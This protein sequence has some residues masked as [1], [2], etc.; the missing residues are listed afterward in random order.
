MMTTQQACGVLREAL[1]GRYDEREITAMTR[2]IFDEVLHYSPVDM[3]LREQEAL[4]SFFE[5]RLSAIVA[6]LRAGEPL[7]YVLGVARFHGHSFAVNRDV[8]IPRPETEQL[9]DMIVDREHGADL[10]VVDLCTGSGCIAISLALA[11]RF[12]QV[13]AVDNSVAALEVAHS[14]ALALKAR[15]GFMMADVLLPCL[16]AESCDVLVSNPP[17][18]CESERAQMEPHVLQYE[19]AEA[20]FVPD[21]D[22]L[23]FYRALAMHA[24]TALTPGGR[25]YVEVNRRFADEVARLFQQ[26]GLVDAAT[27]RDSFGNLRFVTAL[28]PAE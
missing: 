28:R 25:V 19:P 7:Q 17:Y 20:L 14:N 15:V 2:I 3:L 11:L 22:P 5:D 10:R 27:H 18:V 16:K 26:A 13:Q 24:T 23:R 8:L 4:P 1:R 9:V 6:R 12:S 21:A